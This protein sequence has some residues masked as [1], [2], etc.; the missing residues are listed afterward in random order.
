MKQGAPEAKQVADAGSVD[1][2]GSVEKKSKAQENMLADTEH[3]LADI[4]FWSTEW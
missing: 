3:G 2:S 4:E 1:S